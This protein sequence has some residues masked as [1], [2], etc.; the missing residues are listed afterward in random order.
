MKPGQNRR[1]E[2]LEA[3]GA[4]AGPGEV[5]VRRPILAAAPEGVVCTRTIVSRY[6]DGEIVDRH[7]E[8]GEPV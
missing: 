5:V 2:A 3:K 1:L 7:V 6:I 4:P 8:E